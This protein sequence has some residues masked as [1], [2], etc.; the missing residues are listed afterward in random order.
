MSRFIQ[1]FKEGEVYEG[2]GR[3]ITETDIVQFSGLSW[4]TNPI[5][6]DEVYAAGTPFGARVAHGVLTLSA[7][8]GLS[9]KSGYLDGTAIAF[10]GIDEWRFL[11]PVVAGD[12]IRLRWVV[13][14][15]K[16]SAS[17]PD[18]GILRRRIE[19]LNQR[20]ELVQTGIFIT[21]LKAR[22]D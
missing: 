14:D 7:I 4:D 17:K 10:L 1:D 11:I 9:G 8:T 3:T 6:T 20:N 19:V 15:T 2:G 13:L 16:R 18:R 21:M 5:H 22:P 12:T